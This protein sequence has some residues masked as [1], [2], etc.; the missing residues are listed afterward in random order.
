[1]GKLIKRM[2]RYLT[3]AL[4]GK[5]NQVADPKVQLEQAILEAQEQHRRLREQAA[6]VIAN[7]KQTEMR[8]SR[9]LQELEKV[10]GSAQQAL[11]MAAD[12]ESRGDDAKA[13]ELNR[14]AESFA[15]RLIALEREVED[16]KQLHLQS[17]QASDQAKAAVAQ[18]AGILQQKLAERQKLLSQLDQAKMQEQMNTAMTALSE[19]VGQDVPTFDEV[20]DKIEARYAKALGTSELNAQSV[21]SRMLEVEQA[22]LNS[23]AQ[24]RLSQLRSNL[25][26][27]APAGEGGAA[28]GPETESGP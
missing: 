13:A 22:Q 21:E 20:R 15:N 14:A 26:L 28:L 24:A 3:A 23:E 10:N 8:L 7:Q 19:T 18:N 11:L 9:A 12:A 6:N 25:G 1:M 4:T 5:F 2:W 16:L 17:A 27:T